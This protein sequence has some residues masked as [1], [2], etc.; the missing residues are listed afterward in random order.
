MSAPEGPNAGDSFP[1]AEV[2][3]ANAF[4]SGQIFA[5]K[6]WWITLVCL[7]VA[8]YLAWHSHRPTGLEITIDFPEG[9]GLKA[10]D[11]L[12]HR[13]I[14]VGVVSGIELAPDLHGVRATVIL[15]KSA[16]AIANEK[17]EFW[18]VRPLLSLTSISGLDTAVGA[19]YIAVHPGPAE[20]AAAR[21]FQGRKTPPAVTIEEDGTEVVLLGEESYG[22]S[23]G[24]PVTYRGIRVGQI[25]KVDLATE[26]RQVAIH[27]RVDVAYS[28]LLRRGSRFWKTSGVN[29]D[30]GL[31]GFHLSTESLAAM[32]RGGVS[33]LTPE[34][35][36]REME[37][38][39]DGHEFTLAP[40]MEKEWERDAAAFRWK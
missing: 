3:P 14:D 19:K 29:V 31:K 4:H 40:K 12:R 7:S 15:E 18:I 26:A 34:G 33:F 8:I 36:E 5:S 17:S 28:G 1:V 24:S 11:A 37:P 21:T 27:A 25:L 30:F 16:T 32:A 22:I 35:D 38:V 10:G 6:L 9:H 20:S 2:K 23:P 39:E 13:G